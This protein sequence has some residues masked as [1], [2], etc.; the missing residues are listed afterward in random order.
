MIAAL[1]AALA[2]D[3]G[4]R[5]AGEAAEARGDWPAAL[6]AWEVC[7]ADAPDRDRVYCRTRRDTLAPHEA[8]GFVGWSEL[9]A[10]RRDYRALGSDTALARVQAALAANPAGP[11]APALRLWLFNE[12]NRRGD[13]EAVDRLRVEMA[14][15]ARTPAPALRFAEGVETRKRDAARHRA[16]GLTGTAVAAV[17]LG[18]ALVRGGPW[19][20]RSALLAGLV[21]GAIPTVFAAL[22]EEHVYDGFARAGLVVGGCVLLAARAPVWVGVPGTLGAFAAIAWHNGWYPSLGL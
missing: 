6:V 3:P 18:T 19:K 12:H 15:D 14:A 2:A 5:A 4:P 10:V 13:A 17:Y 16:I 22:Y 1:A 20:W 9:Q 7:V 21:L 11:A 8:D